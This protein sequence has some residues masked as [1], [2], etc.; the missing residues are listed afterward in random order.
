[1][2]AALII[3]VL[4]AVVAI[5]GCAVSNNASGASQASLLC[6]QQCVDISS[7]SMDFSRGPCIND[8][9]MEGWV[10]DMAHDPRE[11]VD[12]IAANQCPSFGKSASHFVEVSENCQ[13]IRVV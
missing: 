9:L 5:S 2:R 7:S 1:M 11:S 3:P 4:L 10:C 13:V 8:N 6:R 12:D